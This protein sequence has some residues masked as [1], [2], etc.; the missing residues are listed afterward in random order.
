MTLVSL[1]LCYTTPEPCADPG[2]LSNKLSWAAPSSS[3]T[4]KS[5]RCELRPSLLINA[6]KDPVWR[7]ERRRR[8]RSHQG[9]LPLRALQDQRPQQDYPG[10]RLPHMSPPYLT[11]ARMKPG[12]CMC[13][14]LPYDDAQSADSSHYNSGLS[15]SPPCLCARFWAP[16]GRDHIGGWHSSNA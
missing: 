8:I 3:H 1:Q 10:A 14:C 7:A 4:S 16:T 13:A 9:H 12:L 15:P 6:A 5:E 2:P 11:S